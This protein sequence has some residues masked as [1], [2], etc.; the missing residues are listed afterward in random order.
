VRAEGKLHRYHTTCWL[1]CTYQLACGFRSLAV[2]FGSGLWATSAQGTANAND[3]AHL[4][5]GRRDT[6]RHQ[7]RRGMIRVKPQCL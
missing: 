2:P 5:S 6:F 3:T 1:V 7:Q 4:G